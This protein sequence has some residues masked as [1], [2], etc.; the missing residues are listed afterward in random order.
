MTSIH[1]LSDRL[2]KKKGRKWTTGRTW[3][4]FPSLIS[5]KGRK[6]HLWSLNCIAF[7]SLDW[8]E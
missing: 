1:L 4:E 6:L 8:A 5:M 7:V 3:E 2:K